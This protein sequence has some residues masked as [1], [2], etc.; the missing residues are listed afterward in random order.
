MP[1][2]KKDHTSPVFIPEGVLQ[3]RFWETGDG[4]KRSAYEHRIA[5]AWKCF[6]KWQRINIPGLKR[7]GSGH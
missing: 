6:A 2:H 1:H 4:Q 3:S 5:Q 7:A